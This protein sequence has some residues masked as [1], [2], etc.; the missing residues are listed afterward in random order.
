[1]Q[2]C[3]QIFWTANH[4]ITY[5][6][7]V[8][9]SIHAKHEWFLRGI[10]FLF[11]FP[12]HCVVMSKTI[13]TAILNFQ[14]GANKLNKCSKIAGLKTGMGASMPLPVEKASFLF[15]KGRRNQVHQDII[16][17]QKENTAKVAYFKDQ[18]DVTA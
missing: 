17:I 3:C 6:G 9:R 2:S 12:V 5:S 11:T 7:G 8:N 13:A 15:Y 10:H 16:M 1:M 18:L 14:I 4:I